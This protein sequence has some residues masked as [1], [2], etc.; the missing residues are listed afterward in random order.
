MYSHRENIYFRVI[1]SALYFG[2]HEIVVS[3]SR[4]IRPS[5]C[6]SKTG[7]KK[8]DAE[9][10]KAELN[11]DF[12]TGQWIHVQ[13]TSI[14]DFLKIL[15]TNEFRQLCPHFIF[16]STL[17]NFPSDRLKHSVTS[18]VFAVTS[19]MLSNRRFSRHG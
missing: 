3:R 7:E 12:L 11:I 10:G 16:V 13:V 6:F 9:D 17:S 1:S 15:L 2:K 8:R 19:E 14:D 5:Y 18:D 4:N